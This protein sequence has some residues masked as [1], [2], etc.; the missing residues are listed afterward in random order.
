MS[1]PFRLPSFPSPA[2]LLFLTVLVATIEPAKAHDPGLSATTL[3]PT[4]SGLELTFQTARETLPQSLLNLDAEMTLGQFQLLA[5]GVPLSGTPLPFSVDQERASFRIRYDIPPQPPSRPLDLALSMPLLGRF[6]YGH[7]SLL[8]IEGTDGAVVQTKWLSE[9]HDPV[10][11]LLDRRAATSSVPLFLWLGI[12][13]ILIGFDHLLF[14]FVLVLGCRRVKDILKILTVFTVSHS[15]TLAASA[16]GW[17]SVPGS[18][19]EPIIAAS[20]V[21]M[22]GLALLGEKGE[23]QRLLLTF[24][25]GLVHGLG[26]SGVLKELLGPFG[27]EGLV[28]ALLS[29]NVG[30]EVGQVTLALFVLPILRALQRL[31]AF[32]RF[33]LPIATTAVLLVG[34]YWLV[35][36]TLL[37]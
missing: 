7:K 18:L 22:A 31:T 1:F 13:H 25:F 12:E 17:V 3:R 2:I 32:E 35:E 36:R 4:S 27:A 29:F 30:V 6:P 14:L 37:A 9:G 10:S 33:G 28:A 15:L 23:S 26:F 16:F 34:S 19:V 20:I 24:A 21:Y 8:R 5:D 11:I